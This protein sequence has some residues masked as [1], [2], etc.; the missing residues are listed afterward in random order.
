MDKDAM[1]DGR[2][3]PLEGGKWQLRFVRRLRHAPEK[4]WRALVEPE[5]MAAWMPA[6]MDGERRAGAAL[7]FVF[8]EEPSYDSTGEMLVFDPPRLLEYRWEEEVLRFEVRSVE[9][10]SELTFLSRFE[11]VGKAARDAA[12]WHLCLDLLEE[13]LDGTQS[14]QA[15]EERW[16]P[17][18]ERYREAF[19]P[20]A[21][22]IGPPDWH[23]EW[24]GEPW[25]R[26]LAREHSLTVRRV[27]E[28]PVETL[29]AAWTDPESMR[30]WM[31]V[32]V[33]ADVRPG[34]AY[35]REIEQDGSRYVHT[36]ETIALEPGRRIVQTFRV[37][38]GGENPFRDEIVEVRFRPLEGGRTEVALTESWNG[39]PLT[40]GEAREA[41]EA[42]QSWLTGLDAVVR[43][44]PHP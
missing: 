25:S 3:E 36:G 9:G 44:R 40:T 5:H 7:R 20:E 4:V 30:G 39:P 33:E 35:R 6:R 18:S 12:G 1:I 23:P 43:H 27:Y 8:A 11:E 15:D 32:H 28:A 2:L 10:G 21:S 37:E 24:Q 41:E 19:G 34:G 42:W 14:T 29:Y 17:L 31:G 16:R 22:T 26:D 38:T 13:H